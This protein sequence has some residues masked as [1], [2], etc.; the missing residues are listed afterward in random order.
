[1]DGSRG[2][3]LFGWLAGWLVDL[4]MFDDTEKL[5]SQISVVYS[6]LVILL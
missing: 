6:W 2:C 1:M 3:S 4:I 5:T